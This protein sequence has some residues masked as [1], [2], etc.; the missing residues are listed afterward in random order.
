[1]PPGKKE[2]PRGIRRLD[3]ATVRQIAAG[4]VVERPASVVKELI[5]N[6]LDAGAT[7]VRIHIEGGGLE[8]IEVSDNGTGILPVDFPLVFE[9][10]ATSKIRDARDLGSVRSLGFRGEAMASIAAVSRVTLVSRAEGSQTAF[11]MEAGPGTGKVEPKPSARSQGTTVTVRDLFFNVPAR[12]KFLRSPASEA[13]KIGD[14]VEQLYLASPS[15]TY[16]LISGEREVARYPRTDSLAEAAVIA[17]GLEFAENSFLFSSSGGPG[18]W[19][20]GVASQPG[21]TRGNAGRILLAVNG[22]AFFS[23]ALVEVLRSAYLDLIPKGRYPLALVHLTVEGEGVDVNVHPAKREV[24]FQWEEELKAS[25][26]SALV[27]GLGG[28]RRSTVPSPPTPPLRTLT[29][30]PEVQ[31][32]S[33]KQRTIAEG[34]SAPDSEHVPAQVKGTLGHPGVRIL[35]Q[36]GKLYIVGE[37]TDDSGLLFVMDA[38]AASERVVYERLIASTESGQQELIVPVDLQLSD[39]Q[40]ATFAAAATELAG[41]GFRVEPFGGKTYRVKAI[42]SFLWHRVK[43]ER[44]VAV[45]D[46]L[47][48]ADL[49]KVKSELHERV[50]KTLA[51]HMAIRG[52]DALSMDEMERLVVELYG[53]KDNFTC[54]HGRPIMVTLRREDLDRWF[55]RPASKVA[56]R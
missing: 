16:V 33:F 55:H 34:T 41:I 37:P 25:L 5:E 32:S 54:P 46:E 47:A 56:P 38:H 50:V 19:I 9:R 20:E 1:M 28:A 14:V 52:G 10:H 30:V 27:S 43:P 12:R 6:A 4:E 26:R 49:R 53:T 24:R 36:V 51:C 35:G 44:L 13:L 48:E 17:F 18:T 22:R 40:A 21:L 23:R 45:L 7:E 31:S 42:P 3:E 15:V 29:P 2:A 39:R 11:A 8:V